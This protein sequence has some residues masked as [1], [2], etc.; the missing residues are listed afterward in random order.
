MEIDIPF[1]AISRR[2]KG[3]LSLDKREKVWVKL[4]YFEL[5]PENE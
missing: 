2:I 1:L 5:Y 4:E 3:V